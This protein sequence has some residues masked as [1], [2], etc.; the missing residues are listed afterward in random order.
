MARHD[1]LFPSWVLE[2]PTWADI[3][4][5]L[6]SNMPSAVAVQTPRLSQVSVARGFLAYQSAQKLSA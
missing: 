3:L 5:L 6:G 1:S 4:A 2:S